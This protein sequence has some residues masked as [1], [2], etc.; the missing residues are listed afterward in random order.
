MDFVKGGGVFGFL[1][2]KLFGKKE[3][4]IGIMKNELDDRLNE[5]EIIKSVFNGYKKMKID[6]ETYKEKKQNLNLITLE[7]FWEAFLQVKR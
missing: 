2:R 6:D 5:E 7:G 3:E 1:G 4:K